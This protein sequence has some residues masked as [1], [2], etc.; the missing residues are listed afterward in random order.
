MAKYDDEEATGLTLAG[1]FDTDDGGRDPGKRNG[2]RQRIGAFRSSGIGSW[3]GQ[4]FKYLTAPDLLV[5]MRELTR[6][7]ALTQKWLWVREKQSGSFRKRGG[8]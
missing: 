7:L 2:M 3:T 8:L 1:T 4:D 6:L 5:L